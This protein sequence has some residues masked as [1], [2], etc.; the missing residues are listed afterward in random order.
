MNDLP[1]ARR[2]IGHVGDGKGQPGTRGAEHCVDQPGTTTGNN[3]D[4]VGF[5]GAICNQPRSNAAAYLFKL[6]IA[7]GCVLGDDRNGIRRLFCLL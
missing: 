2:R 3:D 1:D 4:P 7:A 5:G 6:S